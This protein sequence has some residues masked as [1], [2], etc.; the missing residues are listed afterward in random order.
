LDFGLG[1]RVGHT[2]DMNLY[3]GGTFDYFF[4]ESNNYPN[5]SSYS[6]HFWTMSFEGGYDFHVAERLVVRPFGG[7]GIIGGYGDSCNAVTCN[8]WSDTNPLVTFG[9]LLHYFV[10]EKLFI[11]PETRVVVWNDAALIVGGHFGGAF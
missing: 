2:L 7:L 3:L 6:W 1:L 9:G 10:S 11:G 5:R 4:G 8:S